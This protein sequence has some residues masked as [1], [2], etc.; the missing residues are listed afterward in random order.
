MTVFARRVVADPVRVATETWHVI[1]D[2]LT[3]DADLDAKKE[4][5]S[6][7]GI[8]SALIAAENPKDA[9][10]VVYCSCPRFRIYCLYG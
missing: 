9:P 10:I 4:L 6:V 1:V 3:T 2:L 7:T 8:A 5:L